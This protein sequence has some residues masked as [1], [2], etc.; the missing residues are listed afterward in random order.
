MSFLLNFWVLPAKVSALSFFQLDWIDGFHWFRW[1]FVPF[2]AILSPPFLAQACQTAQNRDACHTRPTR[3]AQELSS[4]G[5]VAC[6]SAFG[7][8]AR[9]GV[10]NCWKPFEAF[11][12]GGGVGAGKGGRGGSLFPTDLSCMQSVTCEHFGPK[13]LLANILDSGHH[14][15]TS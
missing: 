2:R 3:S 10:D 15:S 1:M 9:Q 12:G 5:H 4:L 11:M 7:P 14:I 6:R 13:A 8:E